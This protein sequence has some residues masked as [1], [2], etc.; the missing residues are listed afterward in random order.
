MKATIVQHRETLSRAQ[1][2]LYT[3]SVRAGFPSPARDSIDNELDFNELLIQHKAS[4]YVL[5]AQGESMIEVGIHSG[6]LLVCDRA[7]Q[8]THGSVVIAAVDGEFVVKLLMTK[9][10]LKLMSA[11]KEHDDIILQPGQELEIFGVV[12][13]VVKNMQR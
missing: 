6:D 9:P 1:V 2:P 7:I 10:K 4:T 13:F 11:S 3:Y 12:T 5:R 8:A